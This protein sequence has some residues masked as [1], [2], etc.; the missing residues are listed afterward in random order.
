LSPRGGD[1]RKGAGGPVRSR[2]PPAP[3]SF[4]GN[5]ILTQTCGRR[6][7]ASTNSGPA[8]TG[9]RTSPSRP[10]RPL[11]PPPLPLDHPPQRLTAGG[12][13]KPLARAPLR[14]CE[15][16]FTPR[17]VAAKKSGIV[18]WALTL[19]RL[20]L[21]PARRVRPCGIGG[22]GVGRTPPLGAATS[23]PPALRL[24]FLLA[25]GGPPVLTAG[26]PSPPPPRRRAA[27]GTTVP[28]LGVGRSE[29]LF[30][31]LEETPP[32]SRP[33]SPLTGPG[34]AASLMW[35]QGSS[36]LPTAKPRVRSPLRSAPRR[37]F[38]FL[39]PLVADPLL[40]SLRPIHPASKPL[41]RE[42]LRRNPVVSVWLPSR[43]KSCAL[44]DRYRHAPRCA[45][46]TNALKK[47]CTRPT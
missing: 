6:R 38:S 44:P 33:T 11:P 10:S 42:P 45:S 7:Y 23:V 15:V 12:A 37:L 40:P 41:R 16:L 21:A 34:L 28:G 27:L 24:A 18:G 14:G 13:A 30:T 46:P 47:C 19:A 32:P 35:A 43:R 2:N 39:R 26:L 8:A 17:P 20:D 29:G 3:S 5:P 31:P 4:R 25:V 22:L 36:E 1:G 9:R